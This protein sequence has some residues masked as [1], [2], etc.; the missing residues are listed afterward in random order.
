[1]MIDNRQAWVIESTSGHVVAKEGWAGDWAAYRGRPGESAE[2][3]AHHG[4]KLS[5]EEAARLFPQI[6]RVFRWRP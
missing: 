4:D 6:D 3:V 1:M 2:D 5:H